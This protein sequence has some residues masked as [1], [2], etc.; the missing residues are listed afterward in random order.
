MTGQLNAARML[1][2]N[3]GEDADALHGTLQAADFA[4]NV[5]MNTIKEVLQPHSADKIVKWQ[6]SYA[7]LAGGTWLFSD[8]ADRDRHPRRSSGR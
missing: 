8:P 4:A 2:G 1:L 6:G 7:W 5:N 3:A